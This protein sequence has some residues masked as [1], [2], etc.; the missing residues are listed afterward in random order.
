M[1]FFYSLIRENML[2]LFDDIIKNK[3]KVKKTQLYGR[4]SAALPNNQT[5]DLAPLHICE[6]EEESSSP[7]PLY[8]ILLAFRRFCLGAFGIPIL[9]S[10]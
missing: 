6:G 4:S 5:L 2:A 9:L 8:W 7:L 10:P 3:L 1:F